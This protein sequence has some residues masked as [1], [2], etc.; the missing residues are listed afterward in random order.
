MLK[1]WLAVPVLVAALGLAT[2]VMAAGHGRGEG[3]G[4]HF[5]RFDHD[6]DHDRDRDRDRDGWER[7][8]RYE[9]RIFGPREGY[10]PG[11]SRGRKTGWGDCGLP[12]GQAKKYGCRGYEYG[13]RPYYYYHDEG[14][15]II[16]RRPVID[17]HA[18]IR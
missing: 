16:V 1:Q 12:P 9:V 5:A 2:P 15:R 14:G 6:R 17:I 8:G 18:V 4:N 10:P 13:G 7:R 11:W 3:N